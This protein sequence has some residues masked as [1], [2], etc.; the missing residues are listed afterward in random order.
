MVPRQ[1]L[2]QVL[3]AHART[4]SSM[5]LHEGRHV[6]FVDMLDESRRLAGALRRLGVEAGDRVALWLPTMPAW[7]AA[8]FACARLGAIAVAV[9]TRL[10]SRELG[11]VLTRSGARALFYAPGSPKPD[12]AG[13]L[14]GCDPAELAGLQFAVACTD[15]GDPPW[16][17]LPHLTTLA[18]DELLR[19]APLHADAQ[20]SS[21]C[22]I[23]TTSGTTSS[24][25]LVLHDQGS[26]VDHASTVMRSHGLDEASTLLLVPPLCG[27]FGFTMAMA[28]VVAGRPLITSRSW[29]P[30]DAARLIDEHAVTHVPSVDTAIAQLLAQTDRTPAYPSVRFCAYG[31]FSPALTDIVEQADR[32]GLRLVAMYG[33]SEI[34]ASI[35]RRSEA[36][37]AGERA[38]G[39]GH[40]LSPAARVRARCLE[41]AALLPHEVLGELEVLAPDSRMVGYHGDPEATS[42]AFTDDGYYRTGDL[43]YTREGGDFVYVGRKGDTLRLGGFLV[44]PPEIERVV[45]EVEGMAACQV[46]DILVDGVTRPFAF[47][48]LEQGTVLDEPAVVAHCAARLARYKVPCRVMALGHFPLIQGGNGAKVQ[49]NRLRAIAVAVA[50]AFDTERPTTDSAVS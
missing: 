32:R 20:P 7:F 12:F 42:A 31:A 39:G 25:K 24:P 44:S 49:K 38:L 41:T 11:D 15:P 36:A 27:T 50:A 45:C 5:L 46:V 19:G 23:W 9:N 28:T 6:R 21:P 35:A 29:N 14:A 22:V 10:V 37:D 43:G 34:Q 30:A 13:I 33:T 1:T 16:H 3:E 17:P 26:I 18:Y 47:V 2:N 48:V 40:L 4:E 8:L